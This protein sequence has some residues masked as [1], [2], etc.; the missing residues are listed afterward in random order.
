[1]LR[2]YLC[3][4][5]ICSGVCNIDFSYCPLQILKHGYVF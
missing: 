4:Q 3:E 1:M 2:T 5:Y